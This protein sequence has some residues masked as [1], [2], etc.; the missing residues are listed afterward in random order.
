MADVITRLKVDS[1]EYDSKIKRAADGILQLERTIRDA[2][3]SF[4]ATWK[5]EQEFAKGLGQMETVSKTA[6][7]KISELTSAFTDLSMTYKRMTDEEKASPFGQ[8]LKSS[9]EQL[10]GRIQEAKKDLSDINKELEET[11]KEGQQA[12][13]ILDNLA[14]KFGLNVAQLTKLGGALAAAKVAFNTLKGAVESTE[15]TH[16]ELA[17]TM[18]IAD[19]VT[20]QFLRSLATADFSNFINGLQSIIDKTSEAYEAMDEFESYAA[21]F[22]PW[23]QAQESA[24]NTKLMEARAAKAQ[25]DKAKAEQLTQESKTLIDQLAASTKAYG[26]KQTEGGFSTIRSLMGSVNITNEEIAWYADPNNW[27]EAS[28]KAE[29]Y[30]RRLDELERAA[31]TLS[32]LGRSGNQRMINV[33]SE[34]YNKAKAEFNALPTDYKQ[35]YTMQNLRDSGDSKQAQQFKQS[36]S[37]IYG[38]QLAENRIQNLRARADRME[39]AITH[40]NPKGPQKEKEITIQQQI[41]DL[42][43]EAVTATAERQEEIRATIQ[44]LDQELAR[45]KAITESLHNRGNDKP[46]GDKSQFEAHQKASLADYVSQTQYDLLG[47]QMTTQI[48]ANM[49]KVAQNV[50]VETL[51]T[52]LSAKIKYGLDNVDIPS[53]TLMQR[54]M[55]DGMNIDD[56]YWKELENKINEQLQSMNI[57]PIKLNLDTGKLATEGK[58]ASENGKETAQAWRY[59]ASAIGSVNGALQSLEDPS[60]KIAGIV[61]Q[62]VANIALGF[63]QATASPATGAAGVFG[64]IAAATAGVATMAATIAQ[65]KSATKGFAEGGIVPGNSFSGDNTLIRANAGELILDRAA[66]SSIA[67]QLE[68]NAKDNDRNMRPY[69]LGETIYLGLVNY[70]N[71]SGKT[72]AQW[73]K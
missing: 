19:N 51:R 10:K 25:G 64:W 47:T 56:S 26:E 46:F 63:A 57:E 20:D 42:E 43:K 70:L 49:Q 48:E 31:K 34:T 7:G 9:L 2:G 23:Q 12:G 39:G 68:N 36:L 3:E 53:D 35:A 22:Q 50:D 18:A 8:G 73:A 58:A 45:Q 71:S 11:G 72:L 37:N 38:S 67:G 16:D 52:L 29:E 44:L 59:A 54:I 1:Q 33:A 62:A 15:A 5:D 6:R 60:A 13:G 65:I 17:K 28:K 21:R 27:E 14:G 30:K 4:L 32:G 41:A 24:I 66:Q 55:G 40:Y 61:G 69:V